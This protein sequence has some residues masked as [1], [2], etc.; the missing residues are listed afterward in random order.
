MFKWPSSKLPLQQILLALWDSSTRRSHSAQITSPRVA[1]KSCLIHR[2][3]S[4]LFHE[5]IQIHRRYS[6]K[7]SGKRHDKRIHDRFTRKRDSLQIPLCKT[8]SGQRT[9]SF[10]ATSIWNS[11]DNN[12]KHS[13]SLRKFKA[14]MKEYLYTQSNL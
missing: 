2:F 14:F 3:L 1:G 10:R 5:Q 13:S 9:F 8:S 11:V 6:I 7:F 12:I 4:P